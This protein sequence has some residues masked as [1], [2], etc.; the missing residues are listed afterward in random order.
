MPFE[1]SWRAPTRSPRRSVGAITS[2]AKRPKPSRTSAT[3]CRSI[4]EKWGRA[5]TSPSP[6]TS[7]SRSTSATGALYGVEAASSP[8]ARAIGASSLPSGARSHI[9]AV[10][11]SHFEQRLGDLTEGGV[12]DGLGQLGKEV[13]TFQGAA[14]Q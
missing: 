7:R 3:L 5:S 6:A 4:A 10:A 2:L 11:A 14:L 1:G 12:T 9:A 8:R 13:A